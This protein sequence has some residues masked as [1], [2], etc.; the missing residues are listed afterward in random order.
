MRYSFKKNYNVISIKNTHKEE[1]KKI[2]QSPANN[3][4]SIIPTIGVI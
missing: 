2:T 3:A 1:K 4:P